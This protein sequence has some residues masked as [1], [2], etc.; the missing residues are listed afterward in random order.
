[1]S[2]LGWESYQLPSKSLLAALLDVSWFSLLDNV[3][4]ISILGSFLGD[5]G[6]TLRSFS[7]VSGVFSSSYGSPLILFVTIGLSLLGVIEDVWAGFLLEDGS[8]PI[9]A[10]LW[11]VIV[12]I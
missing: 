1:M 9:E 11:S 6:E 5:S 7:S 12:F 4:S 2:I 8:K 3:P 10:M